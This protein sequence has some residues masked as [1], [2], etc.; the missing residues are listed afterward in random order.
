LRNLNEDLSGTILFFVSEIDS[1]IMYRLRG[2][3]AFF[4]D[5]K[6]ALIIASDGTKD[7]ARC[8]ALINRRYQQANDEAVGFIGYFAAAPNAAA[9]VSAVL[10]QV[11]AWLFLT[12]QRR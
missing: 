9:E 4:T 5:V 11:E 10:D 3:S 8:A 2:R 6:H 12:N 7:V 1:N